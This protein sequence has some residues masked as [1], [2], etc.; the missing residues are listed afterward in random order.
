MCRDL[1]TKVLY[2]DL[3]S[4][5]DINQ[6]Q[7]LETQTLLL[8]LS[9]CNCCYLGFPSFAVC[10]TFVTCDSKSHQV[11][12][13]SHLQSLQKKDS[14]SSHMHSFY[15]SYASSCDAFVTSCRILRIRARTAF[16]KLL[17]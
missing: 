9:L 6:A 2:L 5:N 1:S 8:T 3:A 7:D 11:H 13:L 17:D 10:S 14:A 16:L 15:A 4:Y 12:L